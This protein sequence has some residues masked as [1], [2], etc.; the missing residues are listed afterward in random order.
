MKT[1]VVQHVP[2]SP[3]KVGIGAISA[4]GAGAQRRCPPVT[5]GVTGAV[6]RCALRTGN[7]KDQSEATKSV[8]GL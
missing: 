2:S 3:W 1:K 8:R 6:R 4:D 5:P 7:Y